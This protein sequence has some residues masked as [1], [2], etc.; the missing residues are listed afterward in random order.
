M[1]QNDAFAK[2]ASE[3]TQVPK[4]LR[5][6][7]L[8]YLASK[9]DVFWR[10]FAQKDA[11][12]EIEPRSINTKPP[13]MFTPHTMGVLKAYYVPFTASTALLEGLKNG[14][15][16]EVSPPM[17][18]FSRIFAAIEVSRALF[19]PRAGGPSYKNCYTDR[20]AHTS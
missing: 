11:S 3:K 6:L 1:I 14:G 5:Y 16:G 20:Y 15:G 9:W 17:A 13:T 4:L 2:N 19:F 12:G 7:F 8:V 10:I 18:Y